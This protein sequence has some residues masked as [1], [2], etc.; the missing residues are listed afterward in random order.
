VFFSSEDLEV[1]QVLISQTILW[2]HFRNNSANLVDKFCKVYLYKLFRL[3][4]DESPVWDL[5][6]V[7]NVTSMVFD[8]VV[9]DLLSSEL[10]FAGIYNHTNISSFNNFIMSIERIALS[11][12]IIDY[13]LKHSSEWLN[14]QKDCD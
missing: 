6:Q 4:L 13:M 12:E 2:K 14:F 8:F 11:L 5:S 1:A 9:E 3:R 7:T 10:H